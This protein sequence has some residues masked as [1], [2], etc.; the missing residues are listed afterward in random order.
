MT[1][2]PIQNQIE[3]KPLGHPISQ[4]APL[5][6]LSERSVPECENGVDLPEALP[7]AVEP[8]KDE[9]ASPGGTSAAKQDEMEEPSFLTRED[10]DTQFPETRKGNKRYQNERRGRGRG[11]GR[12]GR[13]GKAQ[14]K[15]GTGRGGR[16]GKPEEKPGRGRGGRGQNSKK[17]VAMKR[18]AAKPKAKAKSKSKRKAENTATDEQDPVQN[19]QPQEDVAMADV[20]EPASQHSGAHAFRCPGARP[21]GCPGARAS[22]C[23]RQPRRPKR[24]GPASPTPAPCIK[25][26]PTAQ[27][28]LTGQGTMLDSS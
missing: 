18:P 11:R 5:V 9:C 14:E 6:P 17:E 4:E 2:A 19:P 16:G 25:T 8:M 26:G 15:P 24:S 27:S 13:G 28:W 21:C 7:A 1:A 20:Q 23:P 3:K 12:G 22:C 10:Q